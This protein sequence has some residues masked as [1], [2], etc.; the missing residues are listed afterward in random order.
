[1]KIHP[2]ALV[3]KDAEIADDVEIG[4]GA[5]IGAGVKIGPGS[6]IGPHVVI[7]RGTV[8][9][10]DVRVF[11]GAV[12]GT[13]PQDLK[14]GGHPTNVEIGDGTI[15]REYVT[16][17]RATGEGNATR[18]G[19]NCLLMTNVHI[20][21]ECTVGDFVVM[22]NLVALGGH[23]EVEDHAVIGGMAV[24]HQFVR[25]GR[26][27][28]IG[29]ASGL[30]KDA[31]PFMITFGYPPARVYGVNK[32]GLRRQGVTDNVR[33]D[34]KRAFKFLFRSGLNYSQGL[35]RIR[36]EIE[37]STE[38]EQL[39]EFFGKTKR[40]VSP[41]SR[42]NGVHHSDSGNYPEGALKDTVSMAKKHGA[43]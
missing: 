16:I 5:V 34:I 38:I 26:V 33:D 31:P 37:Q 22:S 11:T 25:V 15:I 29:G 36:L 14:Y 17:N 3:E 20:A 32:V 2:T 7:D 4:P 39:I 24:I 27:A 40:G 12:I 19:K 21:H 28:M 10:S 8:L 35:E 9:G 18:I 6:F 1:M 30:M 13:E 42:Q 23:V 43:I 41:S